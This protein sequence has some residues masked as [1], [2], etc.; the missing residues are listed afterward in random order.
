MMIT[1]TTTITTTTIVGTA[2]T[3]TA[4]TLTAAIATTGVVITTAAL[5]VADRPS[6]LTL[7]LQAPQAVIF[8]IDGTLVDNMALHAEAFAV[9]AQRHGL[10]ALTPADRHAL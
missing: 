6:P 7:I 10:P 9:F 5:I 2:I 1:I 4:A 8:D 3:T